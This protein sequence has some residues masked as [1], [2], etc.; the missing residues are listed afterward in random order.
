VTATLP[1]L[2]L[3]ENN[4]PTIVLLHGFGLRPSTYRSAAERLAAGARVV[5]P[6]LFAGRGRWSY[7]STLAAIVA[8]LDAAHVDHAT[9]VGHSFGG[10]FALA[11]AA[12]ETERVDELVIVDSVALSMRWGLAHDAL[13]D[14]NLLWLDTPRGAVDFLRTAFTRPLALAHAGWWGFMVDRSAD[15]DSVRR[16]GLATHVLWAER[17]TLHSKKHGRAFA[18]RLGADFRVVC[19]PGG[20]GPV[21]HDWMYRHPRLLERELDRLDT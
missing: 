12:N 21:D 11:L 16:S 8:T 17:D 6:D 1:A 7:D 13:T 18:D 14:H 10:A 20:N 19:D 3:G 9:V 2:V 4:V 5:V 15:I